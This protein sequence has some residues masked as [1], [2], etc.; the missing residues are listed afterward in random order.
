M[1]TNNA[2]N[3]TSNPLASSAVTI[4]PGASGDSY[5]QFNINTTGEFR[6]GVDDNDG[7]AFVVSQ[8]SALGTNNTY[9][10]D[11]STGIVTLPLQPAFVA[12][13]NTENNVTGD[14]TVHTFGTTT[15]TTEVLD[16][17]SD[18]NTNG[19]LRRNTW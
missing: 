15:A 19:Y 16:T 11:A 9:R 2:I 5:V 18:Y 8:G 12:K 7:D 14:G 6:I 4:D 13:L 17:G 3:N 1:A 10:I